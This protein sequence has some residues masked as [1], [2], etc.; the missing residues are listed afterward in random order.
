[1]RNVILKY[2]IPVRDWPVV[3]VVTHGVVK[4]LTV[5]VRYDCPVIWGLV[6]I[7]EEVELKVAH[8]ITVVPTGGEYDGNIEDYVGTI[9]IG[10]AVWHIFVN[11]IG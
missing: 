7:N 9:Q 6:L 1:M 11:R 8:R 4:W 5:Q 10:G 2:E 3:T